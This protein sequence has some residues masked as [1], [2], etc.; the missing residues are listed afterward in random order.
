MTLYYSKTTNGFYDTLFGKQGYIPAD[1]VQITQAQY[2]TLMAAQGQGQVIQADANNN[3]ESVA[4]TPT[5]QARAGAAI[6]SGIV[7]T[8][9]GIPAL[10]ATYAVDPATQSQINSII[11]FIMLNSAFPAGVTALPW[12]DTSGTIHTFPNVAS[13]QAFATAVANYVA[14]IA[15]YA[16]SAGK[17]G[18]IPSNAITIP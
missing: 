1:A 12:P 2:V 6:A 7:L 9:T 8:S 16:N 4:P 10:N 15:I 13:F 17:I 14:T 3:P 11:S 18:S 5:P